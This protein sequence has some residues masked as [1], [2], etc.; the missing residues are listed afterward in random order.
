[1]IL[2]CLTGLQIGDHA[3]NN[4]I[5][6]ICKW[7]VTPIYVLQGV[8]LSTAHVGRSPLKLAGHAQLIFQ[9]Y[10]NNLFMRM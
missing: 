5:I 7:T 2:C 9:H 1:M 4:I 3:Y 6:S 8:Q 10:S